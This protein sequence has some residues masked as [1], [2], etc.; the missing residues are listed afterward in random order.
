MRIYICILSL[1]LLLVATSAAL[2]APPQPLDDRLKIELIAEQPDIVTPVGIDVDE[3]GRLYVIESHTHFRP[4]DYKGPQ[5]D[6]IRVFEDTDGDRKPDKIT[7][8]HEGDTHTMS[9]KWHPNGWLYVATRRE[10]FRLRD[11]DGDGKADT[12]ESLAKLESKGNYPHNG[13][14]GFAFTFAGDVYF[15]FGENLG[16]PYKLIAADG[17]TLTGGGEGGNIYR[18][19]P[20]GSDLEHVATGFWNPF[21]I[22]VDAFGRVFA[23]DNDPDS[24]PPCRLLHIVP[25]GDYGFRFRLGRKGLHPFTSWNGEIPGTLPMV[26]G[27]GEAPSGMLA[28]ES[29][30]LPADYLGTL[31]VTSWGDHRIEKYEL[32]PRGASFTSKTE[33]IIQGDEDFRPVGIALAPDGSLYVTDWVKRDYNLHGH[34]RIWR[35]SAKEEKQVARPDVEK[36][37]EKALR[38]K[39]GPLR[40]K[41]ARRLAET[42]EGI[43]ALARITMDQAA[44]PPAR[45]L[46]MEIGHEHGAITHTQFA[47]LL[48]ERHSAVSVAAARLSRQFRPGDVF[49]SFAYPSE[50]PQT[51][52]REEPWP[53]LADADLPL[54]AS[55]VR[56]NA[57][58]TGGI[59]DL[60]LFTVSDPFVFNA[61]VKSVERAFHP[62]PLDILDATITDTLIVEETKRPAADRMQIGMFLVQRNSDPAAARKYL[63]K[64]LESANDDLR[65]LVVQWIGEAGLDEYRDQLLAGLNRADNTPRLTAA[66]LAALEL[67]D[68]GKPQAGDRV[69]PSYYLAK[70]LL[71]DDT[72]AATK[73]M[74]LRMMPADDEQL[75][76]GRLTKFVESDDVALRKE[77]VRTL[78]FADAKKSQPTLMKIAQDD[79]QPLAVRAEAVAGL[80]TDNEPSLALLMRF[81]TGDN[82]TLRDEALRALRSAAGKLSEDRLA[83]ITQHA[84]NTDA[85]SLIKG[86]IDQLK[87]TRPTATDTDAW[88]KLL[89]GKQGN[90]AAGERIFFHPQAAACFRCHTVRGRGGLIGPDLSTIGGSLDRKRL[91]ES[92][93][94][95]SREIAPRFAAQRI[96]TEDGQVHT[97][98]HLGRRP[99]GREDY[100]DPTGSIIALLPADIVSKRPL[101]TSLMPADLH[102][103]MTV[104]EMRD[105]MAF[106]E[107]LK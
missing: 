30:N 65:F 59:F 61:A 78:R 11:K 8:F 68:G 24:R 32:K 35:I 95:P 89:N 46:A 71:D 75:T 90:P 77:A 73:A 16:E 45:I 27:T 50:F 85:A 17:T 76:V 72:P 58:R 40:E 51:S 107:S 83:T 5:T 99:D 69:G 64:Y 74:A 21:A 9:L 80:A 79:K 97:L 92:I 81:V 47:S 7:T 33:P 20:D 87:R 44:D 48:T 25:G 88:L 19:K 60:I 70:L 23:V 39:H 18:M 67:L 4:D 52:N 93:L 38:S 14:C 29:D 66:Y 26:A 41:A 55:L 28:Y 56:N 91:V 104:R 34:G 3:H 63:R 53:E 22:C 86:Q 43:A 37:T 101:K 103:A 105:L 49:P 62:M 15:G 6:R 98:L 12:R 100:A 2:A 102:A 82:E 54:F 36:E 106:L 96:E 1:L 31:L 13:L 57:N 10:V 42:D 84:A 94:Q